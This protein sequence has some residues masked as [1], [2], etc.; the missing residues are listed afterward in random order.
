MNTESSESDAELNQN[1]EPLRIGFVV[2]VL[3]LGLIAG[4]HF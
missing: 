2:V 3:V 4:L 1:Y